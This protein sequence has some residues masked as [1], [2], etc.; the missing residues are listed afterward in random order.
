MKIQEGA[1]AGTI[2][3]PNY[4]STY[5]PK[6]VDADPGTAGIV[7]YRIVA[8]T[9]A[10]WTSNFAIGTDGT[11]S[12][13]NSNLTPGQYRMTVE[14]FDGKGYQ[15]TSHVVV[16]VTSKPKPVAWLEFSDTSFAEMGGTDILTVN[17]A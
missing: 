10:S 3:S 7:G 4:G 2:L 17:L 8:P 16:T 6:A 11:L 13:A 15:D 5:V 1:S 9:N 14:A 12:A